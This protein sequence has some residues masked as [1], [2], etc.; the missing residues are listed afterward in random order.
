M[1]SCATAAAMTQSSTSSSTE[2]LDGKLGSV[3]RVLGVAYALSTAFVVMSTGNHYLLDVLAGVA[4]IVSAALVV[5]G[6]TRRP[7]PQPADRPARTVRVG[8]R[9]LRRGLVA[10]S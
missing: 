4:V 7:A 6:A 5:L 8:G 2:N 1:T 10:R 3:I 9:R